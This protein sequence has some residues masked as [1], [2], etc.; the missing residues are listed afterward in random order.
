MHTLSHYFLEL[1][2]EFVENKTSNRNNSNTDSYT[3]DESYI[4]SA[5]GITNENKSNSDKEKVEE[6]KPLNKKI[7]NIEYFCF[8]LINQ[9]GKAQWYLT[10]D[11]NIYNEWVEKLKLVMNYQ[12]IFDK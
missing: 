3:E 10:P 5:S 11:R 8:I 12:N 4:D 7:N 9:K 1:T 2:Q 6:F